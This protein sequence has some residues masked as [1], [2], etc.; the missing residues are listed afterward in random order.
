MVFRGGRTTR[1]ALQQNFL[2]KYVCARGGNLLTIAREDLSEEVTRKLRVLNDGKQPPI[3]D[4]SHSTCKGPAE[5]K[6]LMCL[7][8]LHEATL[9]GTWGV[10]K[11]V[12]SGVIGR[13]GKCQ[14]IQNLPS[15]A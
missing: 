15:P 6:N 14:S 4:N 2:L 8:N 3:L 10:K 5:E 11:T 9:T 1:S 12:A 7:K 13:L